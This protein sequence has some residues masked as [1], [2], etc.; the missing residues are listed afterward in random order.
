[1][2]SRHV[3][4]RH[5]LCIQAADPRAQVRGQVSDPLPQAADQHLQGDLRHQADG[6]RPRPGLQPRQPQQ[7]SRPALLL[8]HTTR[9][10][11][12]RER[13]ILHDGP[14]CGSIR[15]FPNTP[16]QSELQSE[17][18]EYSQYQNVHNFALKFALCR[19]VG[20]M[21]Y[22]PTARAI[23]I[24]MHCLHVWLSLG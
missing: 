23:V 7:L 13:T 9:P 3:L 22:A 19:R 10:T 17:N 18:C 16:A 11:L 15:H 2:L 12:G 21:T 8:T 1:M 6:L 14:G 24:V 4:S 5:V 20:E